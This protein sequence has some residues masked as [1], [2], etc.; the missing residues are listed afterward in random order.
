MC[1]WLAKQL[2]FTTTPGGLQVK[3]EPKPEPEELKKYSSISEEK[4][5]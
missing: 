5:K 3:L 4:T 1:G 2:S